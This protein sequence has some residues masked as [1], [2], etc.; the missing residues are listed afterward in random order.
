MATRS[1]IALEY[2]DGSVDC[3]YCHWDG[4]LKGVGKT[5]LDHYS[6]PFKVRE[7]MDLGDISSLGEVIGE[8]HPFSQFDGLGMSADD[9]KNQFG[10]MTTAYGRDR[11]ED[12]T[13]ARRFA[14]F[15]DY[16]SNHVYD[17]E[18]FQYI[19]R[20]D[21]VWYVDTDVTDTFIPLSVALEQQSKMAA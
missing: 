9:Y 2:A 18:E 8:K 6:D 7:L 17:Y 11:G 5:L 4:Y 21:G 1:T 20:P 10:N 16:V 13:S 15:D 19:L 12:G 3:I 14:S